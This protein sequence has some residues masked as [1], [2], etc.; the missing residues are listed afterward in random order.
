MARQDVHAAVL[1]QILHRQLRIDRPA[2]G[3]KDRA[4]LPVDTEHEFTR[5]HHGLQRPGSDPA[6]GNRAE[7][8]VHRSRRSRDT[9]PSIAIG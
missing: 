4:A 1:Y 6:L 3:A 8:R 7:T 2:R 9:T 5:D